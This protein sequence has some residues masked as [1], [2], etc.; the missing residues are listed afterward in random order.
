MVGCA[1]AEDSFKLYHWLVTAAERDSLMVLQ[2]H[3]EAAGLQW[4]DVARE[5]Q[6]SFAGYRQ[7]L[8]RQLADNSPPDAALVISSDVQQL[9]AEGLL[10]ELD[11]LAE[12]EA[13]AEVV[14]AAVQAQA[15]Y[16][17]H[18]FAVPVNLHSTNWIWLNRALMRELDVPELD[19]WD[20]LILALDKARAAGVVPLAIGGSAGQHLILFESVCAGLGG[21]EFYRRVFMDLAPSRSDLVLLEK[22]FARMSELRPYA[23]T[24][25]PAIGWSQASELV[26]TGQALLQVQGGWAMAEFMHYGQEQGRDFECQRFPDTQGMVVFSSD[27]IVFFNTPEQSIGARTAFAST[28]MS[29]DL[30]GELN[31]L[32]GATP[33][34]VD[35]PTDSFSACGQKSINDVRMG[36]MRGA[37]VESLAMTGANPASPRHAFYD[38]VSDHFRGVIS[39]REALARLQLLWV[40]GSTPLPRTVLK[41]AKTSDLVGQLY[42]AS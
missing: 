22:V 23:G 11:E 21:P 3:A 41:G 13:W 10:L 30:Q 20:D 1:Q 8:R 9:A 29:K 26:R 15:R 37:L 2:R 12:T 6:S 31:V 32:K 5:Q 4:R 7:E 34:R 33:A 40:R 39:D 35:V 28:L 36:G 27:L 24:L 18:W 19:T 17:E 16:Q 25:D 38:I 42:D 14:P